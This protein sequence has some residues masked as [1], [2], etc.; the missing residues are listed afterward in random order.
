M[1]AAAQLLR[2]GGRVHLI[3]EE[4]QASASRAR[5]HAARWRSAS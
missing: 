2:D 3:E 1:T 5:S 4:P